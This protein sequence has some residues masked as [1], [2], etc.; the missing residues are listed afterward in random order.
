MS[1]RV[2]EHVHARPV[3][4]EVMILDTRTNQYLGLNGSGTLVWSILAGGGSVTDAVTALVTHF[5]VSAEAAEADVGTLLDELL[6]LGL[7]TLAT[8]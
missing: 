2:P 1:Y 4:D 5:E 3:H 8:S 6:R 7:I